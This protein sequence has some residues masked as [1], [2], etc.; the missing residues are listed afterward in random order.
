VLSNLALTPSLIYSA[1]L[2]SLLSL[3]LDVFISLMGEKK[4]KERERE[5]ERE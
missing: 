1:G 2:G 4:R 5:I 3:V